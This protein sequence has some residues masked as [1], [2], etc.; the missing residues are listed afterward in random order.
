MDLGQDN[1]D[2]R[3]TT[4]DLGNDET[5][6]NK[7]PIVVEGTFF[8]VVEGS[9]PMPGC[10]SVTGVD[11]HKPLVEFYALRCCQLGGPL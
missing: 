8:V 6:R 3:W 4:G 7:R 1:H 11:S 10:R 5:H 2:A 9:A